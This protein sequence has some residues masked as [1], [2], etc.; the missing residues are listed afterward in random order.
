VRTKDVFGA[1][2]KQV[3]LEIEPSL[4]GKYMEQIIKK[5]GSLQFDC[6]LFK[7]RGVRDVINRLSNGSVLTK[8][9]MHDIVMSTIP[10][11][12]GRNWQ[13]ELYEHMVVQSGQKGKL[14]FGPIF[15]ELLAKRVIRPGLTLTCHNCFATDWYHVSEFAEE[16]VCRFCFTSQ[17]VNFGSKHEWQFKADGLFQIENSALGSLA[18]IAALWRLE[19]TH[20]MSD[21]RYLS[22][23]NLHEIGGSRQY[24]IDYAFLRVNTFTTA[25]NLAL[26]QAKNFIDFTEPEIKRMAELSQRFA[27]QPYLV[28]STLKDAFSDNEKAL[29]KALVTG[30]HKVIALTRLELDPYHLYDRFEHAPNKYA[31]SFEDLSRN[32]LYLNLDVH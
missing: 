2:F 6:R 10:D 12:Y 8:G 9:N 25:Y 1:L 28:F 31:N 32:T 13:P 11:Q 26:G 27:N 3:G 16:Y 19:E 20:S 23:V 17:R 22:S 15:D 30:G 14:E 21:G 4:P 24:E 7:L 18:G 29:L 5:M